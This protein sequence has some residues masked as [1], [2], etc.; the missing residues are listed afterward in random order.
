MNHAFQSCNSDH[1]EECTKFRTVYDIHT[2]MS[3]AIATS[4]ANKQQGYKDNLEEFLKTF[5]DYIAHILRTKHQGDYFRRVSVCCEF[6]AF[7]LF[8]LSLYCNYYDQ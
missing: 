7:V 8:T 2:R 5:W 1:N 3:A 4:P 6:C